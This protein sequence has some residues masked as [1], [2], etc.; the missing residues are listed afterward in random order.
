[1]AVLAF[2]RTLG[3]GFLGDDFM[4]VARFAALPW[5]DWPALFVREWSGGVW[6]TPLKELR[7][8][9]ALSLMTES[10]LFGGWP[11]GYRLVNLSL[12]LLSATLV[13]QLAW[14]YSRQNAFAALAAGLLF[15]LSPIQAEPVA[16]ITG[17]VDLLAAAAALAFWYFADRFLREG[18]SSHVIISFGALLIGIFSKEFCLLAP[19][20]LGLSW[21]LIPAPE[22]V[23]AV[24]RWVVA[25]GVA[26]LFL[27]YTLA[28]T[29]AFGGNATAA[30]ST[31]RDPGSWERQVSYLGWIF[32]SLPYQHRGEVTHAWAMP[33]LQALALGVIVITVLA[34][35]IARW[36]A[37]PRASAIVFFG[38][39]WWIGTILTLLVVSYFSPRH[40]HFGSAG[41][42]LATGL[43][44]SLLPTPRLRWPAL[45][46]LVVWFA[47]AQF[48]ATEDWQRAGRLTRDFVRTLEQSLERAPAGAVVVTTA[49]PTWRTAWLL[50]WSTPQLAMAPF[51]EAPPSRDLVFG[52]PWNST[53][54]DLWDEQV[55]AGLPR[56]LSTAPALVTVR[57]TDTGEVR[58]ATFFGPELAARRD[59]L[60]E[61]RRNGL[62]QQVWQTWTSSL[63]PP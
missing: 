36:R 52:P 61:L 59:A 9:A 10:R 22:R 7:P 17:R 27:L 56:A 20:L 18:R 46:A 21:L 4:Y 8:F 3:G 33:H 5:S 23:P 26:A 38:G 24:R 49:P 57:I 40:L 43:A 41:L 31:W 42:A 54:Q 37:A 15:V 2:A 25:G 39:V 62:T 51:L 53:R 28:R 16:W 50:G 34:A 29:A 60:N 12:F 19:V 13:I 14:R 55:G 44:L 1:V 45:A 35:A 58:A 47:S 63:T 32:P 11:V 30:N 48:H 6:G